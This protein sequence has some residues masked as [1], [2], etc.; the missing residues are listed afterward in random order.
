MGDF[1]PA[2]KNW[3]TKNAD[4][5]GKPL[6]RAFDISVLDPISRIFPAV[7]NGKK[8]DIF[9]TIEKVDVKCL[10]EKDLEGKV[11]LKVVMHKFSPAGDSLHK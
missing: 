2:T 7:M 8:E 9:P 3:L 5:D 6:E 11:L 4:A 10:Q 1:S